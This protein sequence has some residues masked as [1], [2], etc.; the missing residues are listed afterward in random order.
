MPPEADNEQPTAQ[1]FAEALLEMTD[2]KIPSSTP[3]A[4]SSVE[5]PSEN[6]MKQ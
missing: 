2:S 6:S 1:D 4:P 3:N 5:N